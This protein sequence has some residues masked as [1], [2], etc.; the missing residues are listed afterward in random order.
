MVYALLMALLLVS[1]IAAY[2]RRAQLPLFGA[3]VLCAALHFYA[4][5]GAS[6]NLS[7]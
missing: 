1:L 7:W 5:L 4:L 2:R 3:T 6:L